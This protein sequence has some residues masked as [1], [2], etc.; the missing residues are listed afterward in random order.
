MG[1]GDYNTRDAENV[2]YAI[3]FI[4]LKKQNESRGVYILDVGRERL[5]YCIYNYIESIVTGTY[6]RH[7]D[8]GNPEIS[9][10][11][12]LPLLKQ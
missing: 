11:F 7:Q 6:L 12:C 3:Y 10:A 8:N 5:Y 9:R 4:G 2:R 1:S